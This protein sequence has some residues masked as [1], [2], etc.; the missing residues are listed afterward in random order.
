MKIPIEYVSGHIHAIV[1][2]VH[3]VVD[4]GCPTSFGDRRLALGDR[5]VDLPRGA[6]GV[7]DAAHLTALVKSPVS[8][9]IGVDILNRYDC[10][11]DVDAG[12]LELSDAPIAPEGTVVALDPRSSLPVHE[13][14]QGGRSFRMF[15]DT[16]A[17]LSYLEHPD[18]EQFPGRGVFCDFYPGVGAFDIDT[19][20]V[21]IACGDA[22]LTLPFGRLPARLHGLYGIANPP[23]SGIIGNAA[24][25]HRQVAYLP[26]S[27]RLVYGPIRKA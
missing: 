25:K 10:L 24:M 13:A 4:T 7:T 9:M 17:Q 1:D 6:M 3:W 22:E 18:L 27:R 15:F 8:G 2:G 21:T 20:E 19:Y 12:W 16:G 23:A 5:T 14:R 11:F 26:Q